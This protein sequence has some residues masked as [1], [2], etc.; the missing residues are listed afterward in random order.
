MYTF[1]NVSEHEIEAQSVRCTTSPERV[2]SKD[3]NTG[4]GACRNVEASVDYEEQ[5]EHEL[6]SNEHAFQKCLFSRDIFTEI[7]RY[8]HM[9]MMVPVLLMVD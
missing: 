5:C 7:Q 2:P 8:L 4:L 9:L 6:T 1:I 3:A